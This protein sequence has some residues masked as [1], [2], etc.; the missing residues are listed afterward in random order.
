MSHLRFPR[1]ERLCRPGEAHAP[2]PAPTHYFAELSGPLCSLQE[3]YH[4]SVSEADGAAL[5]AD[6]EVR[7]LGSCPDPTC[8]PCGF[9]QVT[10]ALFP[11]QHGKHDDTYL[12]LVLPDFK[13]VRGTGLSIVLAR[14]EHPVRVSSNSVLLTC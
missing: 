1:R 4:L 10:A 14:R 3:T 13:E 9:R 5:T 6:P 8:K 7:P 12:P 11:D 2:P